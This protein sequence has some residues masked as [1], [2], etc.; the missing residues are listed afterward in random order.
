M[1]LARD[2]HLEP[3]PRKQ[4]KIAADASWILKQHYPGKLRLADVLQ[5]FEML[6]D[7]PA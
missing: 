4:Q 2:Y 1:E 5:L 3:D 6:R 7:E